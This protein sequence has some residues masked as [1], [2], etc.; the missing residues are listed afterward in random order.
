M[1]QAQR[2]SNPAGGGSG[3]GCQPG[4]PVALPSVRLV[5]PEPRCGARLSGV[6]RR[7]RTSRPRQCVTQDRRELREGGA[8]AFAPRS[9]VRLEVLST[10]ST[11]R[12]RRHRPGAR[13]PR[14]S[15]NEG[16]ATSLDAEASL[17]TGSATRAEGRAGRPRP[18][19]QAWPSPIGVC[20]VAQC[21]ARDPRLLPRPR[22]RHRMADRAPGGRYRRLTTSHAG[23]IRP[24]RGLRPTG[25]RA[26]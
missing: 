25:R 8:A 19:R 15:V 4:R 5:G 11:D 6:D 1:G 3:R 7:R 23:R 18:G 22:D 12:W 24:R 14:S 26:R 20:A 16:V 9:P 2:R 10:A 17:A 13:R 21:L